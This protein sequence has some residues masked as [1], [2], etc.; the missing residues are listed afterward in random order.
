LKKSD[1]KEKANQACDDQK[2]MFVTALN[3]N[4]HARND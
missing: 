2:Q 3:V 4:D 1:E